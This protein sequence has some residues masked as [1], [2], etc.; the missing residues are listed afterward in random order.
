MDEEMAAKDTAR[1]AL[2]KTKVE[3]KNVEAEVDKLKSQLEV[4]K[5]ASL[6]EAETNKQLETLRF[7][8]SAFKFVILLVEE[9]YL[10]Y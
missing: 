8:L 2:E 7:V 3:M 10:L 4:A 5:R 6:G 9:L 1:A